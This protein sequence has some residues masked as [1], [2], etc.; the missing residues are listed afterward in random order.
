MAARVSG[1]FASSCGLGRSTI[2]ACPLETV[3]HQVRVGVQA[4]G[5]A[6]QGQRAQRQVAARLGHHGEADQQHDAADDEGGD[7]GLAPA[8]RQ[9]LR[10]AHDARRQQHQESGVEHQQRD[11]EGEAGAERLAYLCRRLRPGQ[12]DFAAHQR[13]DLLDQDRQ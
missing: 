7:P 11:Q 4:V 6:L 2:Y 13:G 3:L 10:Q 12:P 9:Q 1:S 8:V 5:G